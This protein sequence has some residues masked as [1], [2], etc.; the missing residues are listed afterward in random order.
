MSALASL[1]HAYD[2][3]AERGEAPA[4]GYSVEK[5]G[6]LISLNEDGTV[7]GPPID[8][9]EGEGK[10]KT[11]RLMRVPQPTKRTS[12]V[13]PNFLWDK[14]SYVLGVTAGE[15]KRTSEEQAAFVARH[16]ELLKDSDDEGLRALLL[17][18]TSWYPENFTKFG[19]PEEIKDQNVVFSLESERRNNICL[20]DRPAVRALWA[21]LCSAGEKS[22]ATCLV[23]GEY[24]PVARLHPAIKGVWGAQ[25]SGASLV[26]F[27]IDAFT[28]Y[29]HEQ[30][31]NAPVSEAA[32]FAYTTALNHFLERDSGHRVQIGDASTVFWADASDAATAE[33]AEDIFTSLLGIGE[34]DEKVEA[35][36]VGVILDAIR[37]GKP[38]ADLEPDLPKD[39]RF[40]V[41]GLSPNAARLSARFY[42]EDDFGEI[43]TRYLAHLERMRLDPPPREDTPSI[44]RLLIETAS[45]RK[46]ENIPPN[47][48]GEWLRSI[49]TGTPYPLTLLSALLMR[50]RADHDVNALR[51][52]ILKSVLIRN[53]K[54]EVPVALD[55]KNDD[56]GYL[57][58]RLFAVLE[59]TQ[60][61]AQGNVNASI[62]DRYYGAASA[63]PRTVFPLLLRLN[64]HH[65]GKAED[66]S[67][68]LAGY[69]AQQLSEI[70]DKLPTEF[71]PT[72]NLR[73][74]GT[75]ALGYFHQMNR[76]KNADTNE[77]TT[78]VSTTE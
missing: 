26:S 28:S 6:F 8:L 54:M 44:W 63:T 36:K 60:T 65:Q 46:S 64:A 2:R 75:F 52:A 20:H 14:T 23:T 70:M 47:L 35:K 25:S 69:F 17:F 42:I 51:V 50:L 13:A 9:R 29:G 49:L 11:P 76:R 66:K 43:A 38:I 71:P 45:Q 5:I 39:V 7:A 62:K 73:R 72:L 12:G 18:L 27:N 55:P 21:R 37:Q 48:A 15:G 3:L 78:T 67:R 33:E 59:K 61:V 31:D 22:Q 41:L 32:A 10:K 57:L 56:P 19:W 1:V 16:K 24:G 58:G 74:Q 4:F 30:G 53:F 77:S 68:G 40:H 34:V